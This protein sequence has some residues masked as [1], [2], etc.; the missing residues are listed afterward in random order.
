VQK[1]ENHL[2]RYLWEFQEEYALTDL[3]LLR[4][5]ID[6]QQ[7]VTKYM[8]RAERHPDDPERKADEE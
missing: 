8:L 6:A 3:E 1:A 4:A 5:L 7:T 2:K